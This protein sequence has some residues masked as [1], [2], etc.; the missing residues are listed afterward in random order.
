MVARKMER[1]V[2]DSNLY[3]LLAFNLVNFYVQKILVHLHSADKDL[4]LHI[5]YK[6]TYIKW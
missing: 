1:M 2:A 3:A 6:N 5:K 4:K